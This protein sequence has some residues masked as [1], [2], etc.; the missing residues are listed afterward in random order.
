MPIDGK[1]EAIDILTRIAE[2]AP[3]TDIA[4]KSILRVADHHYSSQDWPEAVDAYDLLV[5]LFPKS[6]RA[7]YAA[8]QAAMATWMEFRG[9][10]L[11]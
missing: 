6:D 2:H 9:N 7:P 8:G 5:D 3:G 4:A 1:S 11:R 10:T